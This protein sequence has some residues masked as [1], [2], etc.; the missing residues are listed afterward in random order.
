MPWSVA[1]GRK[2]SGFN[3]STIASRGPGSVPPRR[4]R[5][6]WGGGCNFCGADFRA[7]L[8]TGSCT[9]FAKVFVF[10]FAADFLRGRD[11]GGAVVMVRLQSGASPR[12]SSHHSATN[13]G[14][15]R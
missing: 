5:L 15:E 9:A 13:V 4:G 7:D 11:S 6:G 10:A 3:L 8:R 14:K 12:M 1:G 2:R